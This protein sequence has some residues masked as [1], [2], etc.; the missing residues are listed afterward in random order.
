MVPHVLVD[1]AP[2]NVHVLVLRHLHQHAAQALQGLVEAVQ[3]VVEE[4]QVEPAPNEVL[5]DRDRLLVHLD[6]LLLKI[7]IDMLRILL[8]SG[9][10]G[11]TLGVPKLGVLRLLLNGCVEILMGQFVLTLVKEDVTSVEVDHGIVRLLFYGLIVILLSQVVLADVVVGE[12]TVIIMKRMLFEGD[13]LGELIEG[14]IIVLL[15][16]V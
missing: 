12:A 11:E 7:L 15:L 14:L 2:R 13:S 3:S 6:G 10:I 9:L 5:R 4:A 16:E 1:E 8:G